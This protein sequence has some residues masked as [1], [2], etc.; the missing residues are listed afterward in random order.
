[1]IIKALEDAHFEAYDRGFPRPGLPTSAVLNFTRGFHLVVGAGFT[2][3]ELCDGQSLASPGRWPIIKR[4]D[5]ASDA[6]VMM[7]GVVVDF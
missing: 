4:R 7:S 3:R 5:P 1:M 6:W 2:M